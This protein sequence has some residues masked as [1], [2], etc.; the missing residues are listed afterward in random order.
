MSGRKQRSS[1]KRISHY[2]GVPISLRQ[3][4]KM[5]VKSEPEVEQDSEP[6]ERTVDSKLSR[7]GETAL[8]KAAMSNNLEE[9]QRLLDCGA[10]VNPVDHYGWT[11]LHEA[12][13]HGNYEIAELLIQRGADI[14]R[15]SK[16][17]TT[18]LMDAVNNDHVNV[19]QLLL[20]KGAD[21]DAND[22]QGRSPLMHPYVCEFLQRQASSHTSELA[23]TSDSNGEEETLAKTL[24]PEASE[25]SSTNAEGAPATVIRNESDELVGE[26]GDGVPTADVYTFP[27]PIEVN[28]VDSIPEASTEGAVGNGDFLPT[29]GIVTS[30]STSMNEEAPTSSDAVAATV[31]NFVI[32][33]WKERLDNPMVRSLPPLPGIADFKNLSTQY[34]WDCFVDYFDHSKQ[35]PPDEL[36]DCWKTMFTAQEEQR[37]N[38]RFKFHKERAQMRWSFERQAAKIYNR[39][40][41]SLQDITIQ[42]FMREVSMPDPWPMSE[43]PSLKCIILDPRNNSGLNPLSFVDLVKLMEVRKHQLIAQQ[44]LDAASLHAAQRLQ[45]LEHSEQC[46]SSDGTDY[47]PMALECIPFVK[48]TEDFELLPNSF[49]ENVENFEREI[50]PMNIPF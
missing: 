19:I 35:P 6:K 24:S 49:V 34:D 43:D 20:E 40:S 22:N 29:V 27:E 26:V 41:G 44:K 12:C 45:W 1:R 13:N 8:H 10:H 25:T 33:S 42:R 17:G 14:N 5:I 38:L 21:V 37:V 31:R 3:Q 18:P 30:P 46:D 15:K 28:V 23:R 11:P 16:S 39:L 7:F 50:L 32:K 47:E 2:P 4:I 9:C 36:P 48:V